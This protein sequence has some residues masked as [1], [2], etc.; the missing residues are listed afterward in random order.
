MPELISIRE[1]SR[2][3][4]VS[5]TAVQKAIK[6]G[7]VKI[8]G[9]TP[10]SERPLLSWPEC[11]ADYL[12]NTNANH[13]THAGSQG[14][15]KR[16]PPPEGGTSL[17]KLAKPKAST[18]PPPTD[19]D[20]A[21]GAVTIHDKMDLMEAKTAREIYNARMARVEY[22]EQIGKLVQADAVKAEAFKLARTVR[23][24]LLNLPDRIAHELAHET[25]A[26]AIHHR[27]TTEIRQALEALATA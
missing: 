9:R 2:R 6:S 3:I 4:G 12:G 11:E 1:A 23:D 25:S 5:D 20:D 24:G 15:Y 17:E 7:R 22:E 14:G 27:L 18:L 21:E 10:G 16:K 8:A 19:D 26:T 13:R